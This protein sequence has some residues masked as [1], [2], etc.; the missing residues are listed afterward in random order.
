[1][2]D[3]IAS[4]TEYSRE[5]FF[6]PFVKYLHETQ[7]LVVLE[8]RKP[9]SIRFSLTPVVKDGRIELR[10]TGNGFDIYVDMSFGFMYKFGGSL[11]IKGNVIN[12]IL[13]AVSRAKAE[14]AS[15]PPP[16]PPSPEA[17][18]PTC[19]GPLTYIEKYQ[20]WYCYKCKKY[21]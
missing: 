3:K 15:A 14:L 1:M 19:G 21:A 18:C 5:D 17:T 9:D 6:G 16:P 10:P 20:R 13:K 8:E 7:G 11:M 4:I 12:V 2:P